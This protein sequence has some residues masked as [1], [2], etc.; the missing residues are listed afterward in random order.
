MQHAGLADA[1]GVTKS[2]EWETLRIK[3]LTVKFGEFG[4]ATV[5]VGVGGGGVGVSEYVALLAS[6]L[7]GKRGQL[8]R[9]R[10]DGRERGE[11]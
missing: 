7:R 4:A 10:D 3:F 2:G 6:E 1:L 11:N 9:Q 8:E 5:V